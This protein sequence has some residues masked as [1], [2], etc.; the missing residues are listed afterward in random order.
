MIITAIVMQENAAT[1]YIKFKNL[2]HIF[3]Y[4]YACGVTADVMHKNNKPFMA[5]RMLFFPP[6]S[7]GGY[8]PTTQQTSLYIYIYIIHILYRVFR[9]KCDISSQY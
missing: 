2:I 6:S 9:A 8:N 1:K 4:R 7:K 5:L 3:I